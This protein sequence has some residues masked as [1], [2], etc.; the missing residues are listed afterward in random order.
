MPRPLTAIAVANAKPA[1]NRRIEIADGSTPGLRLVVQSSG[2]KSWAFRYERRNGQAVKITFGPAAGSGALTLSEAR[3][4]ASE[5]RKLIAKGV[6]PAEYRKAERAAEAARIE[7]ERRDALRIDD[8]IGEVLDRYYSRKV[9]GLKSAH[10]LRRLL[11]KEVR[12][13]WK[14]RRIHEIQRRDVIKLIEN[15]AERGA[16]TTAN[17]TLANLRALFNWCIEKD[18]IQANPCDRV[19][20]AK[21]ETARERILDDKELRLLSL[22]IGEMDWPWKQFFGLALLTAQRREEIAAMEW[23]ELDLNAT[24][25]VWVL[26]SRRTKNGREH[27]VPLA[28]AVVDL[29]NGTPKIKGS[30]GQ[31]APFVLTTTGGS[32][33][34]GFSRAKASLDAK[35][36]AI[37]QKEAAECGEPAEKVTLAP[38]RLHD[39]RRTAASGMA[40]LGVPVAVVE[41]VLNHVS[42]TF[43]GIVSVYQRHDF[44]GE[45]RQALT[46][47]ADHLAGLALPETANMPLR[48]GA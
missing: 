24:P 36:L 7:A 45:K 19:K 27:A 30:D 31:Y 16:N 32:P 29:L 35:M 5:A 44:A 2:A 43:A 3:T 37:A 41:K 14:G 20:P 4:A 34:S 21:A 13:V 25:P 8:V 40:R 15:I 18:L 26:P 38:W 22:A 39:L 10:E 1:P 12:G 17:R 23:G 46:A 9:D 47:W 42:G 11:D 33:I 48:A 28:S 6:D